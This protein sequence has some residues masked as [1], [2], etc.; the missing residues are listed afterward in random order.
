MV[1]RFAFVALVGVYLIDDYMDDT[2]CWEKPMTTDPKPSLAEA[3]ATRAIYKRKI[4]PVTRA[5]DEAVN[6][7]LV[8]HL[9]VEVGELT[10]R[11]RQ[12]LTDEIDDLRMELPGLE[13]RLIQEHDNRLADLLEAILDSQEAADA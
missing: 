2:I 11:N 6:E 3:I 5:I 12:W 7:I 4:M 1:G 10:A 8:A 13:N 9:V